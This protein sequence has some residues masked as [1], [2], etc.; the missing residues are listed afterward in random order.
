MNRDI[1]DEILGNHDAQAMN[2]EVFFIE[3]TPDGYFGKLEFLQ[4]MRKFK[5]TWQIKHIKDLFDNI[6]LQKKLMS[7]PK[8]DFEDGQ[9]YIWVRFGYGNLRQTLR[10]VDSGRMYDFI[11]D[12]A[13]GKLRSINALEPLLIQASQ[14]EVK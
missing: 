10:I 6:S 1:I 2:S 11:M 4:L 5:G 8:R 13:H 7:P 12:Y 9:A 3:D 14:L